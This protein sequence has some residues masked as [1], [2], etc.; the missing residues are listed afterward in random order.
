MKGFSLVEV[1]FSVAIFVILG[2]ALCGILAT[3]SLIYT[4]DTALLDVQ[5]QASNALDRIVRDIRASK[6]H[7]ITNI[8]TGSDKIVVYV[9]TPVGGVDEKR[10]AYYRTGSLLKREYEYP[11]GTTVQTVTVAS[12]IASLTFSPPTGNVLTIG[13]AAQKM[14]Y[15]H[16]VT[17]SL[18]QK[19]RLRNE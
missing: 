11:I 13:V 3:G 8:G 17:F 6:R 15:Q 12:D 1:L 19:V 2:A 18:V 14:S 16:L 10:V 7:T 5:Q 4:K 9:P